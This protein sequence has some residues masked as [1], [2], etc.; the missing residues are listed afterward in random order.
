MSESGGVRIR[1][2][3][4]GMSLFPQYSKPKYNIFLIEDQQAGN[5]RAPQGPA[6][7]ASSVFFYLEPK[8]NEYGVQLSADYNDTFG[9]SKAESIAVLV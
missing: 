2:E 7:T 8:S 4:E 5:T 6:W 3:E 1:G 9:S